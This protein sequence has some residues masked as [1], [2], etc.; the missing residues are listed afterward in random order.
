MYIN[1]TILTPCLCKFGTKMVISRGL[2]IFKIESP[3]IFHWK[4]AENTIWA[5]RK[6]NLGQIRSNVVKR[7]DTGIINRFFHIFHGEY[8]LK[9]E[10]VVVQILEWKFRRKIARNVIFEGHQGQIFV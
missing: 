2:A 7:V 3:N 4:P 6:H 5:S 9:Q 10:I 8:I 1:I